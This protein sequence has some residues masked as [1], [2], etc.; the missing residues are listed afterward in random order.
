M[1]VMR[2][3]IL[4]LGK[5]PREAAYPVHTPQGMVAYHLAARIHAEAVA[6]TWKDLLRAMEQSV[7]ECDNTEFDQLRSCATLLEAIT[8]KEMK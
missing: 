7:L 3:Q 2:Q 1:S 4:D 8:P 6:C 5:P